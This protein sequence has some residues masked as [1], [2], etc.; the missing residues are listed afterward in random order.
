MLGKRRFGS[1]ENIEFDY[2]SSVNGNLNSTYPSKIHKIA[3]IVKEDETPRWNVGLKR[4][5][6]HYEDSVE[7]NIPVKIQTP[8]NEI[9][10]QNLQVMAYE[11][12]DYDDEEPMRMQFLPIRYR[13]QDI[14]DEAVRGIAIATSN[15]FA[16]VPY[17]SPQNHNS[18]MIYENDESPYPN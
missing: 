18:R 1:R 2:D 13:G 5:Y 6:V 12:R 9:S 8:S 16:L 4:K 14:L 10:P 7:Q 17:I 15:T 3:S 11:K